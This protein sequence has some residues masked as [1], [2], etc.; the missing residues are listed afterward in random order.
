MI[1]KE[2]K[3][4]LSSKISC[5][6]FSESTKLCI[7]I[8]ICSLTNIW[9]SIFSEYAYTLKVNEKSDVYSFGVVLLELIIGKRPNDS[10]FGD[11]KDIVNWV[12]ESILSPQ[13]QE[14]QE[15]IGNGI[16]IGGVE[17]S[18]WR[19]LD[20]LVDKRLDQTTCDYEEIEKVLN[21][22]LMCTSKLPI[23]RPSM[24]RVVELLKD[25]KPSSMRSKRM[26]DKVV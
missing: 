2:K 24:R 12:T 8:Y 14:D 15:S 10:F 11:N 16:N 3:N 25:Q 9:F 6:A 4:H 22:A 21:V 19:D 1:K 26:D 13:H 23:N 7:Y 18:G 5:K 20:K 17:A